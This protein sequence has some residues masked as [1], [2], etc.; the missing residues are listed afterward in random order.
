MAS[1]LCDVGPCDLLKKTLLLLIPQDCSEDTLE[2]IVETNE[3]PNK[4]VR[5][6]LN[7]CPF[8]G[9]RFDSYWIRSL[10]DEK[11]KKIFGL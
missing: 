10:R 9:V 4:R 2:L 1:N 8:C 3:K 7:Y 5:L 11:K 6:Y